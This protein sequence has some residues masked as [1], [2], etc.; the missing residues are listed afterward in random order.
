M[1][2]II[3]SVIG[4]VTGLSALILSWSNYIKDRPKIII[5]LKRREIKAAENPKLIE[6]AWVIAISNNGR[7]PAYITQVGL[8]LA[9][10]EVGF[11]RCLLVSDSTKG[12]RIGEGDPPMT[13]ILP[14]KT[15]KPLSEIMGNS[16]AVAFDDRGKKYLSNTIMEADYEV[17]SDDPKYA[18]YV[19]SQDYLWLKIDELYKSKDES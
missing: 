7:R 9:P 19:K 11:N 5:E 13:F 15:L 2:T 17:L 6:E 18:A 3:A 12:K 8:E 10:S 4:M 1:F 14:K 16:R